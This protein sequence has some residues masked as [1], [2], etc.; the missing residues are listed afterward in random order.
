MNFQ[1]FNKDIL[2]LLTIFS[3]SPG[4]KFSRDELK[5]KTKM[6][7]VILDNAL[8][9][10]SHSKIILKEKR[11]FSLN[12]DDETTKKVIEIISLNY[13]KLKSLPLEVYFSIVDFVYFLSKYKNFKAYLFGSYSKLIFSDKSDIDIAI[14][15]DLSDKNKKVF[16]K[17]VQK[18][19][20]VYGKE[21]EI[22][23]FSTDFEKQKND[24]LVKEILK[25]GVQLI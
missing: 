4:S 21:I 12:L 5:K 15:S 22:H 8:T 19:E 14:I 24:P 9:V 10:L 20:K 17:I 1:I 2:K 13:K 23:Y 11:F 16:N 18:I 6:N 25:N 7:N 3:I